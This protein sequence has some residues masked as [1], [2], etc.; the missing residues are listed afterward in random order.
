MNCS[1]KFKIRCVN[2]IQKVSQFFAYEVYVTSNFMQNDLL[3]VY[4][5]SCLL[6]FKHLLFGDIWC[7]AQ[8]FFQL[9]CTH[10]ISFGLFLKVL[11]FPKATQNASPSSISP[12][13]EERNG[14]QW[15]KPSWISHQQQSPA[16][17]SEEDAVSRPRRFRSRQV[18]LTTLR[19][20]L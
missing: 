15:R 8:L 16:S 20:I 14:H 17:R 11:K 3:N 18:Y 19:Y 1:S 6:L 10:L 7:N 12:L 9:V 13:R 2:I 4:W 5:T